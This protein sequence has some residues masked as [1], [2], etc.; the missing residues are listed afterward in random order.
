MSVFTHTKEG[1]GAEKIAMM[2]WGGG[3]GGEA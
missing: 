3:G 2:N 1:V